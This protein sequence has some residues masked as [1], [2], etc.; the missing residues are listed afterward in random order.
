MCMH[1][2]VHVSFAC[3]HLY[4]PPVAVLE[5]LVVQRLHHRDVLLERHQLPQ[6]LLGSSG[7]HRVGSGHHD[8]LQRFQ[9]GLVRESSNQEIRCLSGMLVIVPLAFQCRRCSAVRR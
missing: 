4:L 5:I 7:R 8:V 1:V 3:E 2:I 9:P 6:R